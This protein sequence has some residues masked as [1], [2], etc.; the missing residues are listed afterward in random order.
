MAGA[1]YTFVAAGVA[2]VV[3]L[4]GLALSP[5]SGMAVAAGAGAAFVAQVVVFWTFFVWL[6]PHRVALAYGLGAAVRFSVL[7]VLAFVVV[8]RSGLPA[9]PTLLALVAVFLVS[10]LAEPFFLTSKSP[11]VS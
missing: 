2:V 5:V 4:A 6:L 9:A 1:R 11:T 3:A 8:P 10:T 7:A